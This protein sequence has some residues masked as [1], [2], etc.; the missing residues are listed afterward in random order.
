V[1][2]TRI[3]IEPAD[4]LSSIA[5]CAGV[6]HL[7]R[8]L[9]SYISLR[10]SIAIYCVPLK[11]WYAT[12]TTTNKNDRAWPGIEPA[13]RPCPRRPRPRPAMA[14]SICVCSIAC[15]TH[16]TVQIIPSLAIPAPVK[17]TDTSRYKYYEWRRYKYTS[18]V[19]TTKN[20]STSQ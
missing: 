9:H 3:I 19:T 4:A 17:G 7:T 20:G 5:S 16:R 13:A 2:V 12:Q 6:S 1:E 11:R 14:S 18:I 10:S 8:T 15:F